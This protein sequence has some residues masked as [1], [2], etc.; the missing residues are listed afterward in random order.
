MLNPPPFLCRGRA[1]LCV[2][3]E[4]IEANTTGREERVDTF[5]KD[6]AECQAA[7]ASDTLCRA[8]EFDY[9]NRTLDEQGNL[10]EESKICILQY[11]PTAEMKIM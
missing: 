6:L 11:S 1:L 2:G 7:C 5:V 10:Q 4:F 3:C 9:N 8:I